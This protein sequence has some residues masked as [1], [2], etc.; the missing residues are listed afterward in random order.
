LPFYQGVGEEEEEEDKGQKGI[1]GFMNGGDVRQ[2]NNENPQL[3][4]QGD[5]KS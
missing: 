4:R 1:Y 2:H 5:K 3:Q